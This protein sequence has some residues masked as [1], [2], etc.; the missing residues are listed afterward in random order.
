MKIQIPELLVRLREK[1]HDEPGQLGRLERMAYSL[2]ARSLRSSRAY[3]LATWLATRTLGRLRRRSRWLRRLP[4]GL[5]G[6]TR[7]RDFPAPADRRFRDWWDS[8]GKQHGKAAEE[9]QS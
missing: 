4:L 8:E 7:S 9:N 6:W 2:W 1:I 3:R 5:H